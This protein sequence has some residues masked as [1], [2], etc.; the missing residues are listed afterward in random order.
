M[1]RHERAAAVATLAL[2]QAFVCAVGAYVLASGGLS[3]A[4]ASPPVKAA[5]PTRAPVAIVTSGPV[6]P[7]APEGSLPGKGTLAAQLT[8]AMGDSALGG[9]VGAVVVDVS[10]GATL[11]AS[12]ADIGITPASTTKVVTAVAALTELGPDTKIATRVLQ[13][14]PGTLTLVGGG[15]PTLASPRSARGPG[16]PRFA[17]LATL[18]SRTAQALKAAGVTAVSLTYDDSL[19]S[20]PRTAPGWKPGYIPEG[21]VAPVTALTI[22]EGRQDPRNENSPRYADP[23]RTAAEAFAAQLQRYGVRV[24]KSIKRAKAAAGAKEVARVESPAVY[25]LVEHMLTE[26]DNDLAEA[27]AHLVAIKEGRPGGFAG[28]SQAVRATLK[29]LGADAGVVVNDGSGLSTRN[30]IT[31]AA[32]ARLVSLAAS[33]ANPHLRAAISGLPIAGFTGTLGHRYAK[34]EAKAGAGVVRAKTGT[35]NGVNTL[36]GLART[37]D[38]RLV[39]FA[40]MADDV[41]DPDGAVAAL[42]RLAALVSGCGCS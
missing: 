11:F 10:G 5:T 41:R 20:G 27:L 9:N 8:R 21:S 2:L 7:P 36:T 30:R 17:S 33:P 37:A 38:G 13:G 12:R 25:E 34:G 35:L 22:D 32:L 16:Y 14:R 39:A 23:P 4:T 18:A 42:D 3:G 29:R 1:V 28:A 19:F 40:F 6:L 26:S 15:D 24:G 31:P